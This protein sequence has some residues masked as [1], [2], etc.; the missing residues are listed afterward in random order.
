M[1]IHCPR[2]G[3]EVPASQ[4]NV[5]TD[6]G[7]CRSC[8]NV[9]SLSSLVKQDAAPPLTPPG[10]TWFDERLSG[11]E[12]GATTRSPM[13]FFMVP[14]MCIWSAGSLGVIY[15][16]Q[17][18]TGQ[19]SLAMSLFGLPFLVGAL[20]FWSI[21]LMNVAGKIRLRVDG[22]LAELFIGVGGLGWRR[23]FPWSD[24]ERVNELG[25]ST[26]YPGSRG[27]AIALEGKRRVA[28]GGGLSSERRYFVVQTLR[29]KLH[30]A[31]AVA[32]LPYR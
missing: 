8:D 3:H 17:I 2:C 31:P 20:L 24:I 1:T 28:L 14:F 25:T 30:R 26:R 9:F 6:V 7:A 18:T 29:R 22:D 5:A 12:V 32:S 19:F 11:F 15:G 21:T 23:R 27:M 16:R 13:A 10:G 4:V